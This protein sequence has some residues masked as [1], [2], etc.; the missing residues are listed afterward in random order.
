VTGRAQSE[1]GMPRAPLGAAGFDGL[2]AKPVQ[3][4]KARR[5]DY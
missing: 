4:K 1:Q 2:A 3:A 5:R